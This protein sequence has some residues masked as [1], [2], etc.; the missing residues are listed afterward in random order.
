MDLKDG[1][2]DGIE[3]VVMTFFLLQKNGMIEKNLR[4]NEFSREFC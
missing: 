2:F 4:I 1:N 3:F